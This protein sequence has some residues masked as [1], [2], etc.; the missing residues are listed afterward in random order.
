MIEF[1]KK[2]QGIGMIEFAKKKSNVITIVL[3]FR[4]AMLSLHI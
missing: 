1:A 4:A 2:K 3:L